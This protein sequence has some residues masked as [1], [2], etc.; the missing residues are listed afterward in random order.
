MNPIIILGSS[1]SF[2]NTRK[3]VDNIIGVDMFPIVDLS[4]MNITP[5]DYEHK[6]KGDDFLPL[7][8]QVVT[9]DTIVIATPVYW[10]SMS[11]QIKIFFDRITDLLTIEKDL[12][13]QLRGKNLF[14]IANFDA[15]Y[16]KGFEYPFQ[17]TCDY[18]G[19]KYLGTSMVYVGEEN[20]EFLNNNKDEIAKARSS[21]GLDV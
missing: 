1:R 13:R 15:S 8:K 3:S 12:G 19:I 11:S 18:L 10:Y 16:P 6:N 17:Q 4:N 20:Q 9:Y 2:G 14:V 21:L 5:F 7:M